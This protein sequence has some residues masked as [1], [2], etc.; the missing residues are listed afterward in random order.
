MIYL[1]D[2]ISL[3]SLE[4]EAEFKNVWQDQANGPPIARA[5]SAGIHADRL[6]WVFLAGYQSA[7]RL[8]FEGIPENEWWSFVVSED[9]SGQLPGVVFSDGCLSG[10]KT[11]VAACDNVDGVIVTAAG[12]C[13]YVQ[14]HTT[15]VQFDSYASGNFLPDMSTGK[16]C[17][18]SAEPLAAV[19]LKLDFRIA[20]ATALMSAS[21]GYLWRESKRYREQ[22]LRQGCETVLHRLAELDQTDLESL[23]NIYGEVAEHGKACAAIAE[24]RGDRSR[25]DWKQNG[26][27]LSMYKKVLAEYSN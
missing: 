2:D 15:G 23:N 26:R 9:K 19:E 7:I 5:I 21:C 10:S 14:R 11:W 6:S 13:Y 4:S 12:L 27:L 22:E 25:E 16:V 24:V 17:L 3:V 20:E 8:A 18:T 1:P